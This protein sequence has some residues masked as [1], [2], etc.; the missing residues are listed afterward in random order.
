M[1][2]TGSCQIISIPKWISLKEIQR[3]LAFKIGCHTSKT[4]PGKLALGSNKVH[5][6]TELQIPE[7]Q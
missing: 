3:N 4:N 2:E 7:L 6:S 1:L 5:C